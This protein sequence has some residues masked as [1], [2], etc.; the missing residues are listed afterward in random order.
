MIVI[1][2]F[3]CQD[4]FCVLDIIISEFGVSKV[5]MILVGSGKENVGVCVFIKSGGCSGYQYGMVIDDCEFEGDIIVVDWGVKLLVDCMSIELLCGSEVDFVENMMG[6]GFIVYNFNVISFCGCGYFFCI[7]G[8]QL[9]DGE[10]SG[11]CG[12]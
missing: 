2:I 4:M 6:G 11:G 12:G 10:G 8:V 5:Q 9:F 3:E 1:Y 7:D